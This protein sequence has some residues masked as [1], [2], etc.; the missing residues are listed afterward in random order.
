MVKT[1]LIVR[2]LPGSGKTTAAEFLAS[3]YNSGGLLEKY[4]VLSADDYF[5]ANENKEY[6][7]DASKLDLAHKWCKLRT[8]HAMEDGIMK[9]F[10]ANTFTQE[11]EILPYTELAEKYGY[12]V[13]VM[14]IENRH[15]NTSIHGVPEE[16]MIRM[17][18]RF[19]I[20]I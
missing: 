17:K 12:R 5:Y 3:D 7:F 11:K 2:G 14:I 4:P 8:E 13:I 1:L 18:K 16:S 19:S 6:L 20:N 9:I 10:V 15:G